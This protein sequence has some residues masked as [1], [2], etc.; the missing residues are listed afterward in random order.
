MRKQLTG[1][2]FA[3]QQVLTVSHFRSPLLK[4]FV[5]TQLLVSLDSLAQWTGGLWQLTPSV[6]MKNRSPVAGEPAEEGQF[7]ACPQCFE[8]LS[9]LRG[10]LLACKNSSCAKVWSFVDGI[11]NFKEPV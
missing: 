11:Y 3:T 2:G 9:E 5:P 6:F 10:D 7:F 8:P 4:R 1:A